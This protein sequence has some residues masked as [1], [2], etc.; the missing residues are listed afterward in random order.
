MVGHTYVTSVVT[1][2]NLLILGLSHDVT[3]KYHLSARRGSRKKTYTYALIGTVLM[4]IEIVPLGRDG[5]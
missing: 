5:S 2:A 1:P 4:V 3:G